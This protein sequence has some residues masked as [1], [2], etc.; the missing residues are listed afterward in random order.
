MSRIIHMFATI[1]KSPLAT[2]TTLAIVE[3]FAQTVTCSV[4]IDLSIASLL[5]AFL[6]GKAFLFV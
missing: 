4:G 6:K 5:T 3:T 2:Q 1:L